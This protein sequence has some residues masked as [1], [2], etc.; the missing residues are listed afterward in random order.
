[1]AATSQPQ[2]GLGCKFSGFSDIVRSSHWNATC[3][4]QRPFSFGPCNTRPS[5]PLYWAAPT[6]PWTS[7]RAPA[8]S[9]SR[10]LFVGT[11]S[12][13]SGGCASGAF[14][15]ESKREDL[16]CFFRGSLGELL[17]LRLPLPSRL[18][19]SLRSLR[20]ESAAAKL[21]E[22]PCDP[23]LPL[24][25]P[26]PF[27]PVHPPAGLVGAPPP[28]GRQ[29]STRTRLPQISAVSPFRRASSTC[30]VVANS[31]CAKPRLLP[32]A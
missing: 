5:Q 23:L 10:P 18:P 20:A 26:P 24:L 19:L 8:T 7:T 14:A 30:A 31:R 9:S 28:P 16:G 29:T 27:P 12:G 15:V 6:S 21:R 2:V 4:S 25:P 3:T 11:P 17:A 32:V 22:P 1:M 13:G